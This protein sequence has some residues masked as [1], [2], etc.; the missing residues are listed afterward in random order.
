MIPRYDQGGCDGGPMEPHSS[1]DWMRSA[2]VLAHLAVIRQ[3]LIESPP[4]Q[5]TESL[6]A[7]LLEILDHP[8]TKAGA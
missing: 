4:E 1:G 2:D 6:I 5:P 3:I 7:L 8:Q